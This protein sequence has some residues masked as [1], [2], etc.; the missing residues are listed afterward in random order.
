M[1]DLSLALGALDAL[2]GAA[3][4][5]AAVRYG[6]RRA[7][8]TATRAL[9]PPTPKPVC[10]GC[11]HGRSYH[12]NGTGVCGHRTVR[13]LNGVQQS[14]PC[15]CRGYDGPQPMQPYYAPELMP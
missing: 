10:D 2:T 4:A 8:R 1:S 9:P 13:R 6:E 15:T 14:M 7:H 12:H 5:V 11:E 3:V